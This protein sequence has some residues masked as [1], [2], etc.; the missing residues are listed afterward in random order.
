MFNIFKISIRQI[1]GYI[2]KYLFLLIVITLGFTTITLL[3]G[4]SD[5]MKESAYRSAYNHYGGE[6]F[7]LGIESRSGNFLISD[8]STTLD[9]ELKKLSSYISHTYKRTNYM[10]NGYLY[11]EGVNSRQKNLLGIDFQTEIDDLNRM[12]FS[13]GG[14]PETKE[15]III[16]EV[17]AKVLQCNLFDNVTIQ[18]KTKTGQINTGTFVIEGIIEDN[19][20]F[21]AYRTFIDR[22]E[23]NELLNIDYNTFSSIGIFLNDITDIKTLEELLY[24]HLKNNFDV[25][26]PLENKEDLVTSQ[27]KK[28]NGVRHFILPLEVF[29]SEVLDLIKA[30]NIVSYLLY[31][32][33]SA[34]IIISVYVSFNVIISDR[35][36][37]LASMRAM[38]LHRSDLQ[39]M[40][41]FEALFLL[42]FSIIIGSIITFILFS[43]I[44]NFNFSDISGFDIFL[45]KGKLLPSLSL[46]RI[47]L[48]IL[49]LF[50]AVVPAVWIPIFRISKDNIASKL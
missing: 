36:K 8:Q 33:I 27:Q 39:I 45:N 31:I 21:G 34:I 3:T 30:M 9:K 6:L 43:I 48:N 2:S 32:V 14:I 22:R 25:L 20:L 49:I 12:S 42:F 41:I 29:I 28:W 19:S 46:A 24:T 38:G 10:Y 35:T 11:F 15:G 4:Y 18:V 40:F 13:H 5:S 26:P 50:I 7:I 1:T 37:E 44:S 16:S 47:S 17:S 23:L